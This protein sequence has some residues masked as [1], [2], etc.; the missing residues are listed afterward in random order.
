[1]ATKTTGRWKPGQSGNPGGRKSGQ[2]HHA[3]VLLE[4]LMTDDAT[5]VV[6]TILQLARGGDVAAAR[7]VLDRVLPV[8]RDR[9]VVIDLP[10]VADAAGVAAAQAAVIDAVASGEMRPSEGAALAG[11]LEARRRSLETVEL[12]ARLTALERGT[13]R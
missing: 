13:H 5:N 1:M 11:L 7:L 12:E 6:K 3:T 2:R 4:K 10:P 9:R 8:P